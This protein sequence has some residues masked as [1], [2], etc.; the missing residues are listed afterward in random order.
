[1]LLRDPVQSDISGHESTGSKVLWI[2]PSALTGWPHYSRKSTRSHFGKFP[3]PF[4]RYHLCS[5][6][7]QVYYIMISLSCGRSNTEKLWEGDVTTGLGFIG[8]FPALAPYLHCR[9]RTVLLSWEEWG[10]FPGKYWESHIPVEVCRSFHPSAVW[11]VPEE[12]RLTV[13][14]IGPFALSLTEFDILLG[15]LGMFELPSTESTL[16]SPPS[17]SV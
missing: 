11:S 4:T 1:M 12:S 9:V 10:V 6:Y 14:V 8:N 2:R 3:E 17:F 16:L 5:A 7:L 13:D 15:R